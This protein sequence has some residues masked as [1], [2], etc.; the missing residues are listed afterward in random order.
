MLTPMV[1]PAERGQIARAGFPA[2][3]VGAGVVKVAGGG[4]PVTSRCG[5]SRVPGPDQMP[6]LPAG[7]V[8]VFFLGMVTRPADD[9]V[10]G[11]DLQDPEQVAVGGWFWRSGRPASRPRCAPMRRGGPVRIQQGDTPPGVRAPGGCGDRLPGVVVIHDPEP[12]Y[13]TRRPGVPVPDAVGDRNVHQRGQH[14]PGRAQPRRRVQP[15][16]G[17]T[18]VTS[19]TPATGTVSAG[20]AAP[21]RLAVP[22]LALGTVVLGTVVPAVAVPGVAVLQVV[23]PGVV[24]LGAVVG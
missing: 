17:T 19:A 8:M 5:A 6:E 22:R 3:V 4:P 14:R 1:V 18:P 13:L 9:V 2:A 12:S 7:L 11:R 23:V 21:A 10:Q 15:A 24:V 16:A 20:A